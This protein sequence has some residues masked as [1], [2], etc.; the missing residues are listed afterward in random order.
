MQLVR[1]TSKEVESLAG[2]TPVV[3]PFAAVEQH[4]PHLPTG[5]DTF[6]TEGILERLEEIAP[7]RFLSLPVQRFGSSPHHMPFAGTVTLSSRTFLDVALELVTSL[8]SHGFTNFLFL[9]GHGGNQSLLDVAVQEAR[10]AR[11]GL[12]VVH[13]TYWKVAR[14]AFA[15]IRESPSG[16]MGH[17]CEME[18]SVML[19]LHPELVRLDLMAPGGSA[20]RSRLDHRDMLEPGQVGQFRYWDEWSANGVIGDPRSASAEKGR[21]FLDAAAAGVLEVLDALLEGKLG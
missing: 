7:G 9:N 21:R 19:A 5:T 2:T 10:L 3:V 12:R 16:G 8:A 18:T 6:I 11:R 1:L 13:A 14:E 15:A 20:P 4:G 17:A